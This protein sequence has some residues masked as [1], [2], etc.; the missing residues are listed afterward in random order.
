MA[1]TTISKNIPVPKKRAQGLTVMVRTIINARTPLVAGCFYG[2]LFALLLA[3]LY[4][5]ITQANLGTYLSSGLISG[6]VGGHIAHFSGFTAFLGLEIY[7]SFYGLLFGG[8][9]AWIGGAALPLTIE[10]GTIDLALSRPISRTRYYLESWL[11]A[12]I[13]GAIIGLLIVFAI[14]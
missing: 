7:S 5:S 2:V 3:F 13:C 12:I 9:L 11:G 14:W 4:P 10:N 8:I 6:I 1:T